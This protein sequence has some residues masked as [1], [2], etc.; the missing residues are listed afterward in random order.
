M[1]RDSLKKAVCCVLAF[2]LALVLLPAFATPAAAAEPELPAVFDLRNVDTD[3]D[4]IGDTCWVTPVKCQNPFG[5]CWGF[6][7]I[8]SAETSILSSGLAAQGGY[9]AYADPENGLEE[10]NLS[11]KHLAYFAMKTVDDPADPQYGEGL[12]FVGPEDSSAIYNSGGM[13]YYATTLF[14]SG[15]GPVHEDLDGQFEY[16]GKGGWYLAYVSGDRIIPI[17]LL[18]EDDWNIDGELRFYQSYVLKESIVLD[19]PAGKSGADW[20]DAVNAFKEVL[21][22]GHAIQIGFYADQSMPGEDVKTE[23]LSENWAHYT[24]EPTY[25]NHAVTVIGW[26]D[27]YPKENFAHKT[28]DGQDA[29]IPERDGAWLVKNSWGSD[30]REFP[31]SGDWGLLQGQDK[32]V[33]NAATGRW[34]YNAVEDAVHTGYFWLSYCDQSLC[35]AEALEFDSVT[36]EEGYYIAEH[37]YMPVTEMKAL[38][39]EGEI[40]MA[41]V[42]C[43]GDEVDAASIEMVSCQTYVPDV[44]LHVDIYLLDEDWT[45]PTDGVIVSQADA[46]YRYG[47][48]HK[49]MLDMPALILRDRY[50]SVV[51]TQRMADEDDIYVCNYQLSYNENMVDVL[52][53]S[54]YAVGVVNPRE[55]YYG[56]GDDWGDLSEDYD[57][58]LGYLVGDDTPYFAMDNYPIKAY[59]AVPSE[60]EVPR[61]AA[62]YAD[63]D[64][65]AYYYDAASWILDNGIAMGTTP[66]TFSPGDPCSRAQTVTWLWRAAGMPEPETTAS[67]FRDVTKDDYFYYAALWAAENG[68][69]YGVSDGVFAPE[70][71]VTRAQMAAIL[72]RYEKLCGGGFTGAWAFQLE[73]AD[74][75]EIPEWAYEPF[76]YLTMNGIFEGDGENLHPNDTCTRAH[77]V[78]ILQ[79]YFA[80][81]AEA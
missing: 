8:A 46:S 36:A 13:P 45:N 62:D 21:Y 56:W 76:C 44:E 43:I 53:L 52:G 27:H 7:A 74:A 16:R 32:G 34:E 22:S 38:Y 81:A 57:E 77:A 72:Y 61:A 42:F 25:A 80:D 59:L 33:Y 50:F 60:T 47:G 39:Y 73:Y 4:G 58:L 54:D 40:S 65:S 2:V 29:P 71:T 5:T 66:D 11:E 67:P 6:A 35:M 79:R 20:E 19:T 75:E 64:P 49:L 12:V 70:K 37:D 63:L 14:A 41:N 68:I 30:E 26:D 28:L 10:L 78:C 51:V 24:Y 15:I 23:Y 48:F 3:G 18:E 31:N 55:S 69:I 1:K 9:A 17:S